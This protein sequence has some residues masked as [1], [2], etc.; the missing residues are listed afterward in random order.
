MAGQF[1]EGKSLH[2]KSPQCSVNSQCRYVK[3]LPCQGNQF[4]V[5]SFQRVIR[6][7]QLKTG[8]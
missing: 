1:Q 8:D 4:P 7:C 2:G 5:S 6:D 3:K